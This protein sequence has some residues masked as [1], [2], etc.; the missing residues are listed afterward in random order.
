[1]EQG[2]QQ[3]AL[4]TGVD[5]EKDLLDTLGD[6]FVYYGA[7]DGK[8]S[9]LKNTTVASRLKD[10]E[11]ALAALTTLEGFIETMT[12]QRMPDEVSFSTE[13]L[14]APNDKVEVHLIKLPMATPAWAVSNGVLYLSFSMAGIQSAIAYGAKGPAI[15]ENPQFVDLWKDLGQPDMSSF[16]YMDLREVAKEVYPVAAAVMQKYQQEHPGEKHPYLMPSLD[17]LLPHLSPVLLACWSDKDGFHMRSKGPLPG[18]ESFGVQNLIPLFL[19]K[20]RMDHKEPGEPAPAAPGA[21]P[22]PPAKDLL[23][24]Q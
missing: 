24:G 16:S 1:M 12:S 15:L 4:V 9:A 7:P 23:Q 8:G 22:T 13:M 10:P 3:F 19:E 6:S 14:P 21:V 17:Q 5:L 2:L 20:A 18:A 11:K